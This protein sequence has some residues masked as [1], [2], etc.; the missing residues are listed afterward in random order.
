MSILIMQ[1]L[2]TNAV[3]WLRAQGEDVLLAYEDD[4][5][6]ARAGEI[7]ALIYHSIPIDRP[8]MDALPALEVIGK[9]GA[10]IDTIDLDE[11]R[12]RGLR[13]TNVGAGGNAVAVTEHAIMLLLAATRSVVA[14]DA[15]TRQGC[16]ATRFDMPL[17]NE[18][19][20]SRIGIV[21][22]GH[23]GTRIAAVCRDGF[24]CEIG[25]YDPYLD[26]TQASAR[27]G[28][29]FA[30]VDALFAWAD[31]GIIAAPRTPQSTGMIG[32]AQLEALG[33]EGA[34]VIISRGGIVDE[35]A[36]VKALRTGRI[37]AAGVDVYASEPPPDDH[38][39]FAL[40]NIVLT[41]HV[42]GGTTKSHERTSLMVCQQV[43]ALL[44]GGD[45]PV[46]DDQPWL[47]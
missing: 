36:L 37:R 28:R 8:L 26:E 35:P 20:G 33:R 10:G 4:G 1:P 3:D 24:G 29:L 7:R 27:G 19:T 45:A 34:L 42:A 18:I 11:A 22:A 13:I 9:R 21:G 39:F 17:V 15:A 23:I 32:T 6:R 46:V 44:H 25:Y 5:W 38:P 2:P 14:R 30:S 40:D 41:P 12:A 47:A 16:F 31:N 43:H